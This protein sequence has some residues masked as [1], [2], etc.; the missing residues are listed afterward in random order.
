M[1]I[2][3]AFIGIDFAGL[4]ARSQAFLIFNLNILSFSSSA[5]EGSDFFKVLLLER[6]LFELPLSAVKPIGLS[7]ANNF[8]DDLF[9]YRGY[10]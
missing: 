2:M 5:S 9:K 4:K 10:F 1:Y 6:L 7:L 3:K 8:F